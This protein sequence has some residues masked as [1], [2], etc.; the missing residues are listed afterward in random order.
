[1]IFDNADNTT[2]DYSQF[3][4]SG[5]KGCILFTTRNE[6]CSIYGTVGCY[7]FDKLAMSDA[8]KLLLKSSGF[9]ERV[10]PERSKEA[11]MLVGDDVLAQHALAITQAGAFIKQGLCKLEEYRHMFEKEQERLLTHRPTQ[12]KSIYGDVYATFEVSATAIQSSS[13]PK[14]IDALK[15]LEVLAFLYREV[16]PE[17]MFV[18]AWNF[19]LE[20]AEWGENDRIGFPSLWHVNIIRKILH[21]I[22]SLQEL[23]LV[24]FRQARQVLRS[25]SLITINP[26]TDN[27]SMHPLVHKWAK[28]R[29]HPHLQIA[30]WATAASL[31]TLSTGDDLYNTSG[32][33]V[34]YDR[35]NMIEPHVEYCFIQEPQG[36]FK[37]C[38][39]LDICRIFYR[40]TY[41]LYYMRK[42]EMAEKIGNRLLS[43]VGHEI[44]PQSSNCQRVKYLV[45]GCQT[46]LGKYDEALQ[47][48]TEVVL[49]DKEN[50][51]DAENPD[52]LKSRHALAMAHRE[53]GQYREAIDILEDVVNIRQRI[54]ASNDWDLLNTQHELARTNM[55]IGQSGKAIGLF[56]EVI[57]VRQEI[58]PPTN[59][60]LL[61][62]QHE[63]ARANLNI[64]LSEK[65]IEL[66]QEVIRI[67]QETLA[68]IHPNLLISQHELAR[69]YMDIRA[70]EEAIKLLLEVV[71]IREKSLG[72][73]HIHLLDSQR[74]LAEAYYELGEYQ[75]ALPIIQNVVEKRATI[76]KPGHPSREISEELL[77]RCIFAIEK[78]EA[79]NEWTNVGVEDFNENSWSFGASHRHERRASY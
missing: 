69:A 37:I 65:A 62:T 7:E 54:L 74:V 10:W 19:A 14:S 11:Q 66:F 78:E 64:G 56:Q 25:F 13:D 21:K 8:I 50:K 55:D 36:V 5:Q 2:I 58:L 18:R 12:A 9:E 49:F 27:M 40:F 29:L 4:P 16:V 42:D 57:R 46:N 47:S 75:A 67:E 33:G 76:F 53:V 6:Q 43:R 73:T 59:P 71:R 48:L 32:K 72:P 68:P 15:L 79:T 3:F 41:V 38:P 24:A 23:D 31:L 60:D 51:L 30:A 22:P 45:A 20:I 17:E 61:S 28:D 26:E 1:M 77:A 35:L 34:D 70:Y 44:S 52:Y 63:L 39:P